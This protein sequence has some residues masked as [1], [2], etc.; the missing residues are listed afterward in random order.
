MVNKQK[1]WTSTIIVEFYSEDC[2]NDMDSFLKAKDKLEDMNQE[3]YDTFHGDSRIVYLT[4]LP[5]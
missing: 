3:V 5:K 4:E 2:E 1:R